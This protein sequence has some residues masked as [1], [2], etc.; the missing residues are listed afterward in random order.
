MTLRDASAGSFDPLVRQL[1]PREHGV[2]AL[3]RLGK[4]NK[5]IAEQLGCSAKT[6]QFHVSNILQKTGAKSRLRLIV[7][8]GRD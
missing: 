1:T 3:V 8:L 2:L 5:E 4:S 7:S 6:V